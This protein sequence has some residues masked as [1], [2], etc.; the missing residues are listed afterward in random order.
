M[1]GV[2]TTPPHRTM[3]SSVH[4]LGQGLNRGPLTAPGMTALHQDNPSENPL[5]AVPWERPFL[6]L[7]QVPIVGG[8]GRGNQQAN[9][10]EKESRLVLEQAA[11]RSGTA[12]CRSEVEFLASSLGRGAG[13]QGRKSAHEQCAHLSNPCKCWLCIHATGARSKTYR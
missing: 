1:A 2:T 6:P 9:L 10:K 12:P 8:R 11:R 3:E 13:V 7:S 5:T 4:A